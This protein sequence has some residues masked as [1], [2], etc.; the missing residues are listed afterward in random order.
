MNRRQF[1]K[2]STM[3]CAAVTL[4]PGRL[5]A[6][7]EKAAAPASSSASGAVKLPD[8]AGKILYSDMNVQSGREADAKNDPKKPYQMPLTKEEQD[9]MNGS[10]GEVMAKIMKIVVAHGN[11]FGADKLVD[12]GGAA[13][14]SMYFGTAYMS[15]LIKIFDEC[16]KAGLKAYAPYTVN[17]RPYDVYN[18]NNNA[19][20]IELIYEGYALQRDV[21][22]IHSRLGSPDFNYRSCACYVDEVGN[23]PKPGTYVAWAESSA[24]NYGNSALG[25]RTNRNATGMGRLCALLGKAPRFGLMTDEGRRAKWLVEV[26]TT[27]EPDWGLVGTAIGR[28][29][30]ED[31]PYITGLDKYFG[32]KITNDNMHLL[33]AMGSATA[34]SGAVGLYHVEGVTPDAK[35]KGRKLLVKGYKTYVI[36]DAEQERVRRTFKN[37]W[38]KKDAKPTHCFIG[39]PHNTYHELYTWGKKV[40]EALKKRSQKKVAVPMYLFCACVVRDHLVEEQPLLVG[41]MKRAGIK[42]TNMCTVSYAGMKGFSERVS[43]VTNSAKTRNYS[44]VR[45]FPDDVLIEIV[46]TGKMPKGA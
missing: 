2:R 18:V 19:K 20:D 34:S 41:A 42:F 3:A 4:L 44:T 1:I 46:L 45:Y 31:V 22:Y 35:E 28:K 24:V 32:G 13:H 36:D 12:L 8:Y 40:T 39:C 38:T 37:L 17:P 27:K 29:V 26:K 14:T 5:H 9:I 10:K 30:V 7:A 25:I 16:A 11:A 43:A 21:D 15:P 33:K 6:Q 23:A